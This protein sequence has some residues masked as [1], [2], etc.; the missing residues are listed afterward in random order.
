MFC[1]IGLGSNLGDRALNIQLA[2]E[3]IKRLKDTKI[4]KISSIIETLPVGGPAQGKF[5]NAAIEIQTNMSPRD[6]LKNLQTIESEL[7]RLRTVKNGPRTIDLD[8]LFCEDLQIRENDLIVPHPR[9]KEREF[10]LT[11]LRE[12]APDL[13]KRLF[14]CR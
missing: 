8:I 1:Y 14:L 11:P 4:T 13:V 9:I 10:V 3:K 7:G 5:L 6:L 2:I 12:I